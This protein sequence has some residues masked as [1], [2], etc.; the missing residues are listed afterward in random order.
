M[1]KEIDR[2]YPCFYMAKD[3]MRRCTNKSSFFNQLMCPFFRDVT[4]CPR[5]KIRK[6]GE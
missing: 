4:K 2:I 3:N 5:H 1:D 6:G